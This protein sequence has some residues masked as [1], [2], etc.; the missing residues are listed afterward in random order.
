MQNDLICPKC[1]N[2]L[3]FNLDEWGRTPWHLHCSKC[4]INIGV[5]KLKK[6]IE[7]I[8]KYNKKDTYLEYYDNDIQIL[9][10]G[11]NLKINKEGNN[12]E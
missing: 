8:Q 3:Y 2:H 11:K 5:D 4:H 10:E 7:L 9:W 12:A 6:A 1:K